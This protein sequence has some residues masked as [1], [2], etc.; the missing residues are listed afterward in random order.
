MATWVFSEESDGNASA[1]ALELISKARTIDDVSV[2]HIGAGT[3]TA[4]DELGSHGATTVYHLAT[5][6]HLPSASAA[7]ALAALVEEHGVDLVLFGM[8]NTDRDVGGRLYTTAMSAM[9]LEIYYRYLPL[10][11]K[12][13]KFPL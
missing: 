12:I 2:F 4:F 11:A 9:I 3:D 13:E 10:Y 7:A 6:D 1:S 8:N 5:D